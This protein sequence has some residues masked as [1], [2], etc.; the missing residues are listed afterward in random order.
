MYDGGHYWI[1]TQSASDPLKHR[2]LE[3]FAE[4]NAKNGPAGP[5]SNFAI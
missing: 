2:F 4:G 3:C 5:F 1:R